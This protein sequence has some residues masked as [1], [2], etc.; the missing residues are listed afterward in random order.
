MTDDAES[1]RAEALFNLIYA[2]TVVKYDPI[3]GVRC[4]R[5]ALADTQSAL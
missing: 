5:Q 4:C 2:H 1:D 3:A